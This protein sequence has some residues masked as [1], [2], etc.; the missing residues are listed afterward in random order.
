MVKKRSKK[1]IK[2][3]PISLTLHNNN[4]KR[5]VERLC[6]Y[7]NEERMKGKDSTMILNGINQF[8]I[9]EQQKP[10]LLLSWKMDCKR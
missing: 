6:S 8:F 7:Y 3:S 5:I 4:I 1:K 10:E 9:T 2:V